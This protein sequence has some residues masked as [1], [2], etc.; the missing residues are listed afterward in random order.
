MSI[1]QTTIART[2]GVSRTAVSHVLNGRTHMVGPEV[3]ERILDAVEASGY[4]RNALVKALKAN[5]THVIGVIVPEIQ[6]SF[7]SDLVRGVE[8]EA[9][10]HGLQCF[11]CQ[12]HSV[13]EDIR[14]DVV[15]LRE[16]RADGILIA[17]SSSNSNPDVYK[18]LKQQG[19]P[20]VVMDTMVDDVEVSYVGN[21]NPAI[22]RLATRHLL[23]L[24]HRRIVCIQGEPA[25]PGAVQRYEGYC[26]ALKKAGLPLDPELV[27]QGGFEFEGG[28]AAIRELLKRKIRFTGVVTPSDYV[29]LGAIRELIRQG[30]RIPDEISVVGCANLDVAGMVT[31][32][33]TTVDQKPTEIG[34]LAVRLL[35]KQI[36][37]RTSPA[38]K[39][40]VNPKLI[41]RETTARAPEV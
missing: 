13:P 28:R 29:A 21:N 41:V 38:E 11:F 31:P 32:P 2:V 9:R 25:N 4:H 8:R 10:L 5:R 39:A 30:F 22:G 17:P 40:I 36:E 16:Y 35:V 14:K 18:I 7:F 19:F 12:S 37:A 24:G 33:L 3:R 27:I 26:R 34:Q 20:F 6:L 1:S 23:E 15:T